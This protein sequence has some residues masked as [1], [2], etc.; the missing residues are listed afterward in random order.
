MTVQISL[1]A[2][3][4]QYTLAGHTDIVRALAVVSTG[5]LASGSNDRTI[6]IWVWR[7]AMLLKVCCFFFAFQYSYLVVCFV[8]TPYK[9][10]V[11]CPCTC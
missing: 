1:A 6:K 10:M 7:V 8:L 11:G 9:V 3:Q 4:H 5:Q 2:G